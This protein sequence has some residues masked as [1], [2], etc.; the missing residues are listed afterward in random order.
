MSQSDI[1]ERTKP[2]VEDEHQEDDLE[3]YQGQWSIF[4]HLNDGRSGNDP[5]EIHNTQEKAQARIDVFFSEREQHD[6]V[7][8]RG[9]GCIP[10]M[11]VVTAY[12]I[13]IAGE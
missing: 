6:I 10:S 8:I 12:P 3:Q 11:S 1:K 5:D 9:F 2:P 13:P 4:F 7:C